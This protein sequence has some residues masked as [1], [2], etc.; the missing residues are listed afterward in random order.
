M[1]NFEEIL[2]ESIDDVKSGQA[3][4]NDVL[5]RHLE[6]RE[7]LEPLLRIA[8]GLPRMP[9]V[10]P[11]QEFRLR[12][13]RILQEEI[14]RGEAQ[15]R[16]K[17]V[18]A[19]AFQPTYNL[20]PRAA[21]PIIL[22]L[23]ATIVLLVGGGG[24]VY[25]SQS[26]LPGDI[27]YPVKTATERGRLLLTP[28][29]AGKAEYHVELA[30]R[31]LLEV[32]SLVNA[33]RPIVYD[34]VEAI[35][36]E[37]DAALTEARKISGEDAAALFRDLSESILKLQSPLTEAKARAA[38]EALHALNQAEVIVQRGYLLT[39]ALSENQDIQTAP[40]I[41]GAATNE[42][43][44]GTISS[45]APLRIAGFVIELT[46]DSEVDGILAEGKVVRVLG[47]LNPDGSLRA[48]HIEVSEDEDHGRIEIRGVVSATDPLTVAGQIISLSQTTRIEG[49]P[50]VGLMA[51][52]EGQLQEDGL[53]LASEVEVERLDIDVE[54]IVTE[55]SPE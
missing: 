13:R 16:Y 42:E 51:S 12:A 19:R 6:A 2:A 49:I 20:I 26:S 32:V 17:Q 33:N 43:V 39:K 14:A 55:T 3:S 40:D 24:I 50:I 4:I 48:Y 11:S 34:N 36:H 47:G 8:L 22:T 10:R 25:A 7:Q 28:S 1:R 44:K 45:L 54:D 23:I 21:T 15:P 5:E 41:I 9:D 35:A 46:P 30:Q 52:V 18:V 27:L 53:I 38:P 29:A 31:R 37:A